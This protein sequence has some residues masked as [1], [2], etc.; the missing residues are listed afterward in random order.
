MEHDT[1]G[2]VVEGGANTGDVAPAVVGALPAERDFEDDAPRAMEPSPFDRTVFD[3]GRR[4]DVPVGVLPGLPARD[5]DRHLVSTH[6]RSLIDGHTSALQ[7]LT[8]RS[9]H[10]TKQ[11]IGD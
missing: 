8:S 3:S 1:R 2:C 9:A 5:L 10:A 7:R 6:D 11:P 4:E